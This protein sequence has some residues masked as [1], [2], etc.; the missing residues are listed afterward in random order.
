MPRYE[1]RLFLADIVRIIEAENEDEAVRMANEICD[2]ENFLK[3]ISKEVYC[4]DSM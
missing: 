3:N 2:D 4:C 1:A